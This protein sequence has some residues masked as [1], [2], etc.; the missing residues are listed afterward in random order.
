MRF[1]PKSTTNIEDAGRSYIRDISVWNVS[2]DRAHI[3]ELWSWRKMCL[4]SV[5]VKCSKMFV[6]SFFSL[7]EDMLHENIFQCW[8]KHPLLCYV[9]LVLFI[10]WFSNGKEHLFAIT[11]TFILISN[12]VMLDH[13]WFLYWKLNRDSEICILPWGITILLTHWKCLLPVWTWSFIDK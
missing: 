4:S 3:R 11:F 10:C 2:H 12:L 6:A 9:I 13:V 8:P 7:M 5:V 1:W